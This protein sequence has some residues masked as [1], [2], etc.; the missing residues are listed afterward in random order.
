M[1]RTSYWMKELDRHLQITRLSAVLS[2]RISEALPNLAL[3]SAYNAMPAHQGIESL[4][5]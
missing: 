1:K 3:A 4:Y 5:I 2:S